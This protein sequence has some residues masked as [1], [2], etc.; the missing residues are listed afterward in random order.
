[1]EIMSNTMEGE[2]I[3]MFAISEVSCLRAT[4][5]PDPMA[6]TFNICFESLDYST[7]VEHQVQNSAKA[8][9]RI[10][11]CMRSQPELGKESE[12]STGG[13]KKSIA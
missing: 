10:L 5:Q 4:S 8:Y 1:M 9:D 12:R 13:H 11:I 2:Y 6:E 7:S 3:D